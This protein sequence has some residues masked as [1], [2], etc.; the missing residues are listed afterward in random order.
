MG[1]DGKGANG[2][3]GIANED[4]KS[5]ITSLFGPDSYSEGKL[6]RK[7]IASLVFNNKPKL[8]AL[9][10]IV[11]PATI[12][13]AEKWMQ[14]QSAPY[15]IKEAALIFESGSQD[16][17]DYVIGV[18]APQTLRLLR[19]MKRDGVTKEEVLKRMDNQ[20][21]EEIK[22]RLCNFV[23]E[24]DEQNAVLPQVLDLHKKLIG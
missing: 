10:A 23:I 11:H 5:E 24:N 20:I 18:H 4:L 21:D 3:K 7:Y 22:M 16:Q 17:L 2:R 15:L 19:V 8:D 12:R 13:A 14:N 6:N 1:I 9:N